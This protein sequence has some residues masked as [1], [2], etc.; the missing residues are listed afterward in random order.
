ML[1]AKD[2]DDQ[3]KNGKQLCPSIGVELCEVPSSDNV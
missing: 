2:Q 3:I 1:I